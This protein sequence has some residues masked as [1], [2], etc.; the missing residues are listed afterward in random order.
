MFENQKL[1]LA[2]A[3]YKFAFPIYRWMYFNFK[4]KKDGYHLQLIKP[5]IK[6]GDTVLDIGANIGFF[7]KFLSDCVGADGRVYCFEPDATNFRH[8]S[9]ELKSRSNVTLTQ[10]AVASETGTLTLYISELLNVDHRTYEPERYSGKYDVEKTS[11]DD[12]V[13]GRFKVDFIKMDIQGFETDAIKGMKQTIAENPN[14]IIFTEFWPHGLK[15]AGSSALE[16]YDAFTQS[17][18]TISKVYQQT[19]SPLSREEVSKMKVEYFTD[20]NVLLRR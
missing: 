14:L 1:K 12:F 5:L 20:V 19:V 18:F 13:K 16:L 15:S 7:G 11:I 2:S 8:L 9:R 10:K 6:P 4:N 17:G 3:L